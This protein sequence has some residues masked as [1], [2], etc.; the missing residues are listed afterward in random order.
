MTTKTRKLL[1]HGC[2]RCH[3]D[4]LRDAQDDEFVCIQCGRRADPAVVAQI[5]TET[6][7]KVPVA[8]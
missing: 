4:L 6:T 1:L 2:A 5:V 7:P 8:A 3:G